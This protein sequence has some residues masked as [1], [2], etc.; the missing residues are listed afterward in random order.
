MHVT[1]IIAA[2]LIALLISGI[3]VFIFR[4]RGPWGNFWAFFIILFLVIWAGAIWTVPAGPQYAGVSWL[5]LLLIG[6]IMALILA[7]ALP[8]SGR[9]SPR[10][11]HTRDSH[12]EE[13][14]LR[15]DKPGPLVSTDESTT[16]AGISA[17]F[18]ILLVVLV[19]VV[20]IGYMV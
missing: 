8:S 13:V 5:P 20:T 4:T 18:W 11:R 2:V 12:L 15:R 7:A 6:L 19:L 10:L 16:S 9:K 17:F 1:A 14:P 3:F